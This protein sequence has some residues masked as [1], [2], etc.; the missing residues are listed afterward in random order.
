M[1][2]LVFW[3]SGTEAINKST[4]RLQVGTSAGSIRQAPKPDRYER[5]KRNTS[6]LTWRGSILPCHD[7]TIVERESLAE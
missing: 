4:K 1:F 3:G 6:L 7:T 5:T 2:H